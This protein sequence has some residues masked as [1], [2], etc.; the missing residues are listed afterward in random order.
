MLRINTL[1][2]LSI[3]VK[4][5]VHLEAVLKTLLQPNQGLYV[6]KI[7]TISKLRHY[8]KLKRKHK[9]YCYLSLIIFLHTEGHPVK[10]PLLSVTDVINL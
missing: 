6:I 7:E 10:L 5:F 4:G 8:L 3:S 9:T 1:S 2:W